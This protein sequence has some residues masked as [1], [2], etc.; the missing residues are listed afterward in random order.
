MDTLKVG[1]DLDIS[2]PWGMTEYIGRGTFKLRGKA[3]QKKHVGMIAGGTGITPML[4]IIRAIM[5]DPLDR[6]RRIG[7]EK[8]REEIRR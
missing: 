6:K 5:R 8:R 1:D 2:G 7:E 3:V 4:Q